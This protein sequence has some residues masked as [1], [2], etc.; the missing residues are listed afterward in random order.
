MLRCNPRFSPKCFAIASVYLNITCYSSMRPLYLTD[1]FFQH[2]FKLDKVDSAAMKR[3]DAPALVGSTVEK[4]TILSFLL[5]L[6]T[7]LKP[8]VREALESV[9][10][11]CLMR[12]TSCTQICGS[13]LIN[14][15]LTVCLPASR[16]I[17]PS[18]GGFPK[19]GLTCCLNSRILVQ[20]DVCSGRTSRMGTPMWALSGRI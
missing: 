10:Q 6:F 1:R 16:K 13:A 8:V 20:A 2:L 5:N 15:I 12:E 18:Y 4:A 7:S 3:I 9:L 14:K 17:G 19:S 11:L